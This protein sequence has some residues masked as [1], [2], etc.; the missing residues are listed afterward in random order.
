MTANPI[1]WLFIGAADEAE[2][3]KAP[4]SGCHVAIQEF[5][6]FTAPDRRPFARNLSK[7]LL[8]AWKAAGIKAA[9]RVNPLADCGLDDLAAVMTGAPD[10]VLLPKV[11]GPQDILDLADAVASQE[12]SLGL[13]EGS[14]NLVPNLESA[15]AVIQAHA[16]TSSHPRVAACLLASEDLVTDLGAPRSKENTELAYA[17]QRFIFDC[18]AAGVLAIDCPYTWT[19]LEGLKAHCQFSRQLGYK[20]KAT[21]TSA[22]AA[23]LNSAFSPSEEELA[24]AQ[25]IVSA[26]EKAREEGSGRVELD[27]SL[28]EVPI[29]RNAKRLLEQA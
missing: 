16:I 12:R 29:Y 28:I 24:K 1:S 9:A 20:A 18:T 7:D 8:P 6:D 2:L 17:R 11:S 13:P 3:Q 26:F 22:H 4:T 21:I 15:S 19:D 23:V 10:Y 14:T 27:G 5:E 25:R